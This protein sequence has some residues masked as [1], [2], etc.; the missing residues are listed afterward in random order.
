[1]GTATKKL[2]PEGLNPELRQVLTRLPEGYVPRKLDLI[3]VEAIGHGQHNQVYK[4]TVA[5]QAMILRMPREV[6]EGP[7]FYDREY[8]NLRLMAARDLGAEVLFMDT[9]DGTLLTR[10]L[11]GRPMSRKAFHE[12]PNACARLG[13]S[14]RR[15]HA[16]PA[17]QGTYGIF[18][19][20]DRYETRIAGRA[21][22]L[23]A[24]VRAIGRGTAPGRKA[25]ERSAKRRVP[26]HNDPVAA[27]F[28]DQGQSMR[29]VDWQCAGIGDPHWELAA[30]CVQ[31]GLDRAQQTVLF[32]AYYRTPSRPRVAW[33]RITLFKVMCSYYWSLRCVSQ[34]LDSESEDAVETA[35]RWMR[36]CQSRLDRDDIGRGI[37]L[38][39]P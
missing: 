32:N 38:L 34:A 36:Q 4:L 15:L 12:A 14:Y 21:D 20:I 23:A 29:I 30:A 9:R 16:S 35:Q 28:I 26:T 18:D 13:A 19:K 11:P 39:G 37:A 22:P 5:R 31:L 2:I 17:M 24:E 10:F 7:E 33:G 1:M 3:G 25:L 8:H 27:N 6:A